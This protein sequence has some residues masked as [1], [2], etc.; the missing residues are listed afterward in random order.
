MNDP[1]PSFD[2]VVKLSA[3]RTRQNSAV[4][5]C[6]LVSES[7]DLLLDQSHFRNPSNSF[8]GT[9]TS[10][11]ARDTNVP[12]SNSW[13]ATLRSWAIWNANTPEDD[14]PPT[15]TIPSSNANT[16]TRQL[17][18]PAPQTNNG[19]PQQQPLKILGL[20]IFNA[21][22]HFLLGLARVCGRINIFF[23]SFFS[24]SFLDLQPHGCLD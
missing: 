3:N 18:D 20:K 2:D 5:N 7:S 14:T 6:S 19:R 1:P 4:S 11:G 24:P 8:I 15:P 22:F 23:F 10:T 17:P 16:P 13:R 12:D 21:R 9:A